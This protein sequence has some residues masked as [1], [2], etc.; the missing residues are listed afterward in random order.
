M[1]VSGI[2]SFYGSS[3]ANWNFPETGAGL[4]AHM[5]IN[6]GLFYLTQQYRDFRHNLMNYFSCSKFDNFSSLDNF[7]KKNDHSHFTTGIDQVVI[8]K[9]LTS[10]SRLRVVVHN[11]KEDD[12]LQFTYLDELT[13]ISAKYGIETNIEFNQNTY[14]QQ[15]TA[16]TIVIEDDYEQGGFELEGLVPKVNLLVDFFISKIYN[17]YSDVKKI[18]KFL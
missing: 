2:D 1:L 16:P 15:F 12:S 6:R 4:L 14:F 3:E 7:F 18:L 10:S 5:T 13:R 11:V 8:L 17:I 9:R